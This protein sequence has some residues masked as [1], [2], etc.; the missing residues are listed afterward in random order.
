MSEYEDRYREGKKVPFWWEDTVAEI[1]E[2]RLRQLNWRPRLVRKGWVL[3][4]CISK[5]FGERQDG[6]VGGGIGEGKG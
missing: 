4:H 3:E 6:R 5:G 1:Y 2:R